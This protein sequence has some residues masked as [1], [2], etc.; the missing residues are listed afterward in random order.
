MKGMINFTRREIQS[1]LKSEYDLGNDA[2]YEFCKKNFKH[3]TPNKIL[4]KT[5]II[6]RTYAVSLDRGKNKTK[7]G[8]ERKPDINDDFYKKKIV[9]IFQDSNID[10]ELNEIKKAKKSSDIERKALE[11][12]CLLMK[13]LNPIN[14]QNKRSFCSKYLHFHLPNIFFL[15][16]SRANYAL[17][18]LITKKLVSPVKDETVD[19]QYSEFYSKAIFLKE[20]IFILTRIDLNPRQLDNLLLKIAN[21]KLRSKLKKKS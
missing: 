21:E 10:S 14:G 2:L 15:Y 3:D 16:D 20:I 8:R 7:T 18:G 17:N 4:A 6:G 19:A 1:I 11:L 13:R 9:P 12:H 5:I